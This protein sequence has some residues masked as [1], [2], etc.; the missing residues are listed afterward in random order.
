MKCVDDEGD[1]CTLNDATIADARVKMQRG[2]LHLIVYPLAG[3]A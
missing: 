3:L 2:L 1:A